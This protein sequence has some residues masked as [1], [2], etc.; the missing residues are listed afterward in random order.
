MACNAED[1]MARR[2]NLY[3]RDPRM[4]HSEYKDPGH[5][6]I[7]FLVTI[8]IVGIVTCVMLKLLR[9]SPCA[10]ANSRSGRRSAADTGKVH[11]ASSQKDMEDIIASGDV[12][13]VMYMAPWCGHCQ[14]TKPA[15]HE[16]ASKCPKTVFIMMDC[17]AH[18]KNEEAMKKHGIEGFPTMKLY[19]DGKHTGSYSG[20]RSADDI[21]KFAMAGVVT[22]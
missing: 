16:A 2:A 14:K 12:C 10:S 4:V 19:K 17:D 9:R 21:A 18:M 22:S 1:Y 5:A 6:L 8:A 3:M 13:F 15:F 7:I 20:D 11:E